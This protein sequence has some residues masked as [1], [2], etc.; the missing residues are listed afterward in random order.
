MPIFGHGLRALYF[1]HRIKGEEIF[2]S[3]KI[4]EPHQSDSPIPFLSS[5]VWLVLKGIE[6]VVLGIRVAYQSLSPSSSS[7]LPLLIL[8]SFMISYKQGICPWKVSSGF[9][10]TH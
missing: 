7:T 9:L 2:A 5:Y 10:C 3:N 6:G 8:S 4:Q 1:V